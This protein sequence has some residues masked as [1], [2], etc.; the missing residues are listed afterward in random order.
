MAPPAAGKGRPARGYAARPPGSGT[1]GGMRFDLDP[2][3]CRAPRAGSFAALM[4]LYELNYM[5]LRRLI[6]AVGQLESHAV[7]RVADCLPLHVQVS[8]R[9]RYTTMLRMTYLF[10]EGEG[11]RAL[12]D[13]RVRIYHDARTAEVLSRV[14]HDRR[15]HQLITRPA[16]S[17]ETRW[18]LNRFFH[19]W[20]GYCLHRGHHF[21]PRPAQAR[22]PALIG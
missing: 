16:T 14:V 20:L 18:A 22:R 8:E 13:L 5:R 10:S 19:R 4:E 15:S 11:S 9:C 6:P 7:S 2:Q 21:G 17:L 12:P 1:L 3:A